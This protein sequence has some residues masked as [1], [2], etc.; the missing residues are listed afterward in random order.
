M[1]KHT[2]HNREHARESFYFLSFVGVVTL[3]LVAALAF[4]SI[5]VFLVPAITLVVGLFLAGITTH[6]YDG[7]IRP[8][9]EEK[10]NE[11]DNT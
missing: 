10:D 1:R 4:E 11:E 2:K 6:F 5:L 7:W 8:V 9:D 3:L